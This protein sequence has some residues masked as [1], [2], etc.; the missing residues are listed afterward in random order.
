MCV[1]PPAGP[2]FIWDGPEGE[3][4]TQ[5]VLRR[6]LLGNEEPT[7]GILGEKVLSQDL[8]CVFCAPL[9]CALAAS[10]F[11]RLTCLLEKIQGLEGL[12]QCS[13]ELLCLLRQFIQQTLSCC[14][15]RRS[16]ILAFRPLPYNSR[17]G[18]GM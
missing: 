3:L 11:I 18:A 10:A 16:K 14:A 13:R 4:K 15:N 9:P 2:L 6:R 7:E 12:R 8:G 17:W 1:L 5:H